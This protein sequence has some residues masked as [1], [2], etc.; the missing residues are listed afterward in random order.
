MVNSVSQWFKSEKC[1][2]LTS[3]KGNVEGRALVLSLEVLSHYDQK[4]QAGQRFQKV[5]GAF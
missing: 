4:A 2:P 1:R 3:K 5:S